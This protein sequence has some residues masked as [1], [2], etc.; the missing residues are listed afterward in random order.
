METVLI[1]GLSAGAIAVVLCTSSIARPLRDIPYLKILLACPFCT[2]F[3]ISLCHDP[4]RTVFATMAIANLTILVIHWSMTTYSNY[5]DTDETTTEAE[6]L[7]SDA[8]Q[9]NDY[10]ERHPTD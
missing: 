9:W 6:A 2:S 5:E 3:W 7:S 10:C 4:T 8:P 1:D